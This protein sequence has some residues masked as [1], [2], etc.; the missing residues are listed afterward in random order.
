MKKTLSDII[1]IIRFATVIAWFIPAL[2]II[3]LAEHF[4]GVF[5]KVMNGYGWLYLMLAPKCLH[6]RSWFAL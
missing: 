1:E 5:D 2:P 6:P 3:V 4:G